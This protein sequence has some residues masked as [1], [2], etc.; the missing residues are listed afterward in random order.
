MSGKVQSSGKLRFF[1]LSLSEEQKNF[2]CHFKWADLT[3][4]VTFPIIIIEVTQMKEIICA[5]HW[6]L[7][8]LYVGMNVYL[9]CICICV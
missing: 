2:N 3:G 6:S 7:L 1:M 5:V 9:Y 8:Y 4:N